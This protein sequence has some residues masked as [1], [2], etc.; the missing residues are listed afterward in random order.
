MTSQSYGTSNIG[1]SPCLNFQLRQSLFTNRLGRKGLPLAISTGICLT[2]AMLLGIG[3]FNHFLRK[4]FVIKYA[5][6]LGAGPSV[7]LSA[8]VAC[9]ALACPSGLHGPVFKSIGF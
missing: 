5:M 6:H 4:F 7:S 2:G 8:P 1:S 3:F 9:K